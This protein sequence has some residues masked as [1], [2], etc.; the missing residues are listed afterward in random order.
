MKAE[1]LIAERGAAWEHLEKIVDRAIKSGPKAVDSSDLNEAIHLYREISA[2][3]AVLRTSQADPKLIDRINRLLS[4]AH[5]VLYRGQGPK[6]EWSL[7]QF[8]RVTF[9][10]LFRQTWKCTLASF[11][12]SALFYCMAYQVVQDR[13]DIAADILGGMDSEFKGHKEAGDI[14]D[15]FR[16]ISSPVLSSAVTTNNIKVALNAFA[17]GIT[18]GIGTIYI[19]IFNGTMLGG[20]AGAFAHSGIEGVFWATVLPHG[21]LELSAI[22]VAGGAG[23]VMGFALWCP[24]R[25]T[26]IRALREDAIKAVQIALGLIPAFIVAG[27]MEGFITP[28]EVIPQ[29]VK[30]AVGVALALGFWAHLFIGG[31]DRSESAD[32]ASVKVASFS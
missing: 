9:P 17:L 32:A 31:L 2:D 16:A 28:S 3:L 29:S 15:R 13:P 12:C 24:G 5:G 4:R 20:I 25:R 1:K 8:Y 11:L 6:K 18:F 30:V 19:L 27:F 7:L 26:R 23:L 21:A 22:V 14:Q 10:R